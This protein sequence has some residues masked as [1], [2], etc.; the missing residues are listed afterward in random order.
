MTRQAPPPFRL[1]VTDSVDREGIALLQAD[2]AL[3]VDVVSTLPAPDLL[4]RIPAYDA[5]VGRSATRISGN[6]SG[7]GRASRWWEGRGW[8]WTT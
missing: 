2:P 5:I 7:R 3:E 8:A 4:E 1:L 6:S